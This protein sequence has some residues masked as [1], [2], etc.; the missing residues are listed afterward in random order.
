MVYVL[1]DE[2]Q[3]E[4][5][6]TPELA[7]FALAGPLPLSPVV[8]IKAQTLTLKYIVTSQRLKVVV[9]PFERGIAYAVTGEEGPEPAFFWSLLETD[10]ERQAMLMAAE[11]REC[12][13]HLFNEAAVNVASAKPG[14]T[15]GLGL[16]GAETTNQVPF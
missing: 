15:D 16:R 4:F 6:R 11:G 13:L 7:R 9:F 12:W 14:S 3:K 8:L 1:S 2:H 10:D 5:E